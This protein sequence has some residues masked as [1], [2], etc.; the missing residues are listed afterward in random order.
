[1]NAV[2]VLVQMGKKLTVN[3]PVM[4]TTIW[5]LVD[6]VHEAQVVNE[7]EFVDDSILA[8]PKG[9]LFQIS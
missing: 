1:M 2:C 6:Q 3:K 7:I 8:S 5:V 9:D 4:E